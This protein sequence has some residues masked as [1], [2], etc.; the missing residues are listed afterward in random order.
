MT[1]DYSVIGT[2]CTTCIAVCLVLS[3]DWSG[4]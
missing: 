4:E 1:I 2:K 3:P